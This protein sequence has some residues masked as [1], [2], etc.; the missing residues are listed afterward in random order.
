MIMFDKQP[1]PY[2]VSVTVHLPGYGTLPKLIIS[3]NSTPNDHT[4]DFKLN[5][6][7]EYTSGANHFVGRWFETW[8]VLKEMKKI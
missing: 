1:Y 4:S 2:N 7:L 6:R 3:Y 5:R 8:T